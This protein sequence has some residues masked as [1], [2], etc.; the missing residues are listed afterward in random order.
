MINARHK[1]MRIRL[2]LLALFMY[3]NMCKYHKT[4]NML[5][6]YILDKLC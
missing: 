3:A 6:S 5:K 1:V 4:I 2:V